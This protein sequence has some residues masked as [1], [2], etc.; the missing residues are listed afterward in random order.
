M[1]NTTSDSVRMYVERHADEE[2]TYLKAREIARDLE[3]SPKAVGQYLRQ[4]Q[5]ELNG[6]TLT[7]WGRSKSITWRLQKETQ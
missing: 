6:I 3:A 1:T 4:L 7:K 5:D 2:P